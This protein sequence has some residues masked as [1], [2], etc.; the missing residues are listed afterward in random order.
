MGGSPKSFADVLRASAGKLKSRTTAAIIVAG[1]SSTRMGGDTPKQFLELCGMPVAVHAMRAYEESEYID[2]IYIV[3]R[4]EDVKNKIYDD[5]AEKFSITKYRTTVS[6]GKT[7]QESVLKGIEALSD[8]VKFV[9]IADAA[10]PL[11]TP[12]LINSVCLAAYRY[13]AATAGCLAVDTIK[14]AD[15]HKFITSTVERATAW[16]VSTPQAFQ[17]PLYRAAAYSALDIG[18]EGTDDNSLVERLE[19]RVK[20]IDCGRYNIKITEKLDLLLAETILSARDGILREDE[21]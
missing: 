5:F 21:E 8:D 15:N 14:T 19:H 6:G 18:F 17:L 9:A 20:L 1:G 16:Q 12:E 2:Q 13:G 7:R 3:A 10:R 11:T 4:D